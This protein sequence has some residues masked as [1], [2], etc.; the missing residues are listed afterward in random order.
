[1]HSTSRWRRPATL[2]CLPLVLVPL[3]GCGYTVERSSRI[4]AT[5][6]A[7]SESEARGVALGQRVT[8]LEAALAAERRAAG[9]LAALE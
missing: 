3:A 8:E 5:D 1:M 4:A 9:D 7:L 6:R 2:G